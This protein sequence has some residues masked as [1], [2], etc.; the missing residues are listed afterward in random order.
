MAPQVTV[1]VDYQNVHMSGHEMFC[2]YG[3]RVEDCLVHPLKLAEL[4]VSRRAPGGVVEAVRVYRGRPNPQ[5]QPRMVS[6]NDQ[7]MSAWQRD[8][9]VTVLRR[10]LQYP[11]DYGEPGCVDRPREKG[12]DVHLAIDLVRLGLLGKYETAILCSRDT[13]LVPALEAVRDLRGPHVEVA[14]WEGA[15]RLRLPGKKLWCHNLTR[16]D[17]E[18]VRDV[19]HYAV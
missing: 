3:S 1:F 14:T 19:R 6:F 15:S 4:L 13:D 12:V 5:H 7:Q 16:Q 17:W 11:H 10:M 8:P 9:R 2:D 18:A